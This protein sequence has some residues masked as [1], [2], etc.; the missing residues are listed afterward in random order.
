[1]CREGSGVYEVVYE[2]YSYEDPYYKNAIGDLKYYFKENESKRMKEIL[3]NVTHKTTSYTISVPAD[4]KD[5]INMIPLYFTVKDDLE[6][7][8]KKNKN[9]DN[10]QLEKRRQEVLKLVTQYEKELEKGILD[11]YNKIVTKGKKI[12]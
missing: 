6:D 11:V 4:K 12:K 9:R 7:A 5:L 1:M 8:Y 2:Y 10:P 3:R